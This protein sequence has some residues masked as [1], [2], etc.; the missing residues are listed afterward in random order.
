[1][2]TYKCTFYGRKVGAIGVV[3]YHTVYFD[4]ENEEKAKER[5]YESF[6]HCRNLNIVPVFFEYSSKGES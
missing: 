4:A 1:M 3:S 6:E 5:L 2:K